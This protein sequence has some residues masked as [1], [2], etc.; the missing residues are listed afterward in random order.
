LKTLEQ[1]SLLISHMLSLFIVVWAAWPVLKQPRLEDDDYRYLHLVQ[2]VE[3]GK[4]G[5]IES[6]IVENRW[7]HLWFLNED[8][9]IRFFR[10]TVVM[11]Y[12]LDLKAW[13]EHHVPGLTVSN[14][15]FHVLSCW[16]VGWILHRLLGAGLPAI[17]A[18]LLFAGL[19]AHAECIWYIAGRTDTLAAVGFLGA[20]S[21]HVSGRRWW[22]LPLFVFGLLTKELVI[23]APLVLA[24]YDVWIEK[25]RPDWKLYAAYAGTMI[26]VLVLKTIALNGA[27]SDFVYPYLVRPFTPEFFEHLW[28]QFRSYTGNLLAAEITLPFADANAVSVMHRWYYTASGVVLFLVSGWLLRKDRKFWLLTLLGILTWLPTSMVYLSER[29][30]Y[31][32]SVAYAGLLGL[33]IV[34][35]PRRW[36]VPLSLLLFLYAGFQAFELHR[37]CEIQAKGSGSV[38]EMLEQVEPERTKI[39]NTDHLLLVNLPGFFVRAQFA[40]DIFRVAFDRPELLVDVLT[41]MP[42]QNGRVWQPGE[43]WPVMGA[44]VQVARTGKQSLRLTGRVLA[45]DQPPHTVQEEDILD[46]KWAPLVE[47]ECFRTTTLEARINGSTPAGAT[48]LSFVFN[49]SLDGSVVLVWCA[50]CS[51]LS[52]H[53]WSRRR[54]AVVHALRY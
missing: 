16:L 43:A 21:L 34:R 39:E 19:A 49:R 23:V 8:G 5:L 31:L 20:F 53:P 51:D 32:P 2:Q 25:R 14:V 54:K 52:E 24:A 4:M 45:A 11:T 18:S 41:M 3:A 13:G 17:A 22:A 44:G 26:S 48:V 7:D 29:Y 40:Q 6:M 46:F 1:H 10:P 12:A 42:E 9:K 35:F 47:G 27:G 33:I 15:W 38:R 30:L 28:L 36:R 50:D 37:R